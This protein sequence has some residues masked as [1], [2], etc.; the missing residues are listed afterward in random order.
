M[1][2]C[3]PVRVYRKNIDDTGDDPVP[4]ATTDEFNVIEHWYPGATSTTRRPSKS[5]KGV[6]VKLVK[7]TKVDEDNHEGDPF[8]PVNV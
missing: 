3:Q 5:A 6:T 7:A 1:K 8:K 2:L 4:K